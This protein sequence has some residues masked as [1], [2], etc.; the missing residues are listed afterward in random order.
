MSCF[1]R[2][3]DESSQNFDFRK[4]VFIQFCLSSNWQ[5]PISWPPYN[6]GQGWIIPVKIS[7]FIMY[8]VY[9][10]EKT[11]MNNTGEN[12]NIY[13]WFKGQWWIIPGKIAIF[14][15]DLKSWK[16]LFWLIGACKEKG[17]SEGLKFKNST[18]CIL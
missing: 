10:I 11:G 8:H 7:V 15:H 4:I 3:G 9:M 16:K 12:S 17:N 1:Q 5:N 6:R 2:D 18:S 14:T 13:T